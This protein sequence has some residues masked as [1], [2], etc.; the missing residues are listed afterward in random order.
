MNLVYINSLVLLIGFE[1]NVGIMAVKAK[2]ILKEAAAGNI[3]ATL[4][5][6]LN[7]PGPAGK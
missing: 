4:G 5:A 6:P 7:T 2:R 1:L 3:A